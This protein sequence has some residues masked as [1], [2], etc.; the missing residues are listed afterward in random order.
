[1]G[2]ER[3]FNDRYGHR[4]IDSIRATQITGSTGKD[5]PNPD[6]D[7]VIDALGELI[8]ELRKDPDT[9]YLLVRR[10]SKNELPPN[11]RHLARGEKVTSML[12]NGSDRFLLSTL[13]GLAKMKFGVDIGDALCGED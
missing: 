12:T 6:T 10:V 3:S 11:G 8:A 9:E 5:M 7:S 1:M 2:L 4:K 13:V